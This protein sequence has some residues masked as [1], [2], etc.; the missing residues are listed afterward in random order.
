MSFECV[1]SRKH[2]HC[3]FGAIGRREHIHYI[4]NKTHYAHKFI[5]KLEFV[6]MSYIK[7]MSIQGCIS[8][9]L[10]LF[11][12]DK[13]VDNKAFFIIKSPELFAP[14][15]KSSGCSL[16]LTIAYTKST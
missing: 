5:D 13:V 4:R 15:I 3:V 14:I 12:F 1:C 2:I 8:I 7:K 10:D 9:R 6:R 11:I 16:P